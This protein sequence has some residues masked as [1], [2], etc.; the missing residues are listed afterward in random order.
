MIKILL[1][2]ALISQ[3]ICSYSGDWLVETEETSCSLVSIPPRIQLFSCNDHLIAHSISSGSLASYI[4]NNKFSFG[5]LNGLGLPVNCRGSFS[6]SQVA[7]GECF[8]P[9]VLC[10]FQYQMNRQCE[11]AQHIAGYYDR[12]SFNGTCPQLYFPHK[13]AVFQCGKTALLLSNNI[14]GEPI[15]G[16]VIGSN[17]DFSFGGEN[18]TATINPPYISGSCPRCATFEYKLI[19]SCS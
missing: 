19:E 1:F 18:C 13:L 12:A 10:K 16:T 11:S 5:V 14:D 6:S 9:N 15:I 4:D 17:L 3:S 2:I 7:T 8:G